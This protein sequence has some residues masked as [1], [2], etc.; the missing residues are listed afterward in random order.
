MI[1]R[2]K[3][4]IGTVLLLGIFSSVYAQDISDSKYDE[5]IKKSPLN[6]LYPK[7]MVESSDKYFEEFQT[8]FNNSAIPP[9]YAQLIALSA[10]VALKCVYCIPSHKI[11]AVK[12]GATE[13][14]MKV[15]IQIAAEIAR[16]S[17][18][19]YG[20]EWD[21]PKTKEVVKKMK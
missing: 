10:S 20:N 8:L 7:V 13:E 3:L 6:T 18:L 21:L 15:A 14:E 1:K 17:T 12:E 5:L 16:F 11:K 4:S 2:N 19:L 9:K